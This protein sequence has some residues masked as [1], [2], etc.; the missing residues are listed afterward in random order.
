MA[1]IILM[2]N[3]IASLEQ[4]RD[5]FRTFFRGISFFLLW[6]SQLHSGSK[7]NSDEIKLISHA[8]T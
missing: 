3:G 4:F 7:S 5:N 1:S 6:K 8:F 2:C